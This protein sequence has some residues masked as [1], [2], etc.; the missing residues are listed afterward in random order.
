MSIRVLFVEDDATLRRVLSREL[1]AEGFEVHAFGSAEEALAQAA[2]LGPQ[3]GLLDLRLPG[4]SGLELLRELRERV[5]G[6]ECVVLTAHGGVPEAVEAMR[7]GAHDFLVKPTHLDVVSQVLRRAAEK[8]E[9]VHENARLRRAAASH[10]HLG[11]LGTSAAMQELR[12]LVT[13]IAASDSAVL[14]TGE[15]GSG[16][17]LLARNLHALSRRHEKPWVVV[18]CG[19]IADELVESELFGHEK[20]AFSGADRKTIGLFEAAHEGTLFLDEVGELPPPL[21]PSLLRALQFGEIRPVGSTKTRRVDVRVV[22]ATNRDLAADVE[23]G[24]FRQDLFYRLATF[25]IAVPPLRQRPEDIPELA[26]AFLAQASAKTGRDLSFD[27]SAIGSLV[28]HP[29]PGNVRELENAVTR[30]S[31]L[32]PSDVITAEDVAACAFGPIRAGRPALPTLRIDELERLATTAA[33]ERHGGDRQAAADEL[34]IS[35]RTLYNK[36]KAY[37]S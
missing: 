28:K 3:V 21:Q 18:N 13:R 12:R 10:E 5:P 34:G 15:Q 30:L 4:K 17:E 2:A 24:R 25:Q 23:A 1:S 16:K 14:V 22:S 36:L 26:R 8:A 32:A 37:E 35:V 9:L 20:G 7:L 31:V 6:V 33:L 11:M 29:W 19:A 27:P